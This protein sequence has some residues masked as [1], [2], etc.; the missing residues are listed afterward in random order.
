MKQI[1]FEI[2][3]PYANYLALKTLKANIERVF[4]WRMIVKDNDEFF[5]TNWDI[6]RRVNQIMDETEYYKR[7]N[8]H[9]KFNCNYKWQL[10]P[11]REHPETIKIRSISDKEVGTITVKEI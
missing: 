3:K 10:L 5:T 2:K 1:I 6:M 11:N 8:N 9:E 4:D 7:G